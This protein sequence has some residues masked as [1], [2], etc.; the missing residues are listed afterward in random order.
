[1]SDSASRSH[2]KEPVAGGDPQQGSSSSRRPAVVEGVPHVAEDQ[3]TVI[4]RR[5]PLAPVSRPEAEAPARPSDLPSGARL[6]HFELLEYVGGGG[7]GRVFRALDTRLG[8][9]VALKV[10]SRDQ[11]GQTE[12][13]M[14]FRN[15]ARSAA[16]LSHESIAQVYFV[17]EDDGL[18]F[19]AFEFVEGGNLRDLVTEKGALPLAEALSYTLQVAEALAHAAEYHIVH[20]DIKPS[21]VLITSEGRVKLIDLGLAR[22]KKIGGS[23]NDLTASGVTL[24]TFDYI[25]PEQARD[26]RNAD[27]RSDIYSL[28]CTLFFMF[29][30]RPPFPAGTVLQKLLQHQG[31]EPPDVR[32]FRPDLPEEVSRLVRKMMAKE[33][34]RRYQDPPTLIKALLLLA[35]RVGLGVVGVKHAAWAPTETRRVSFLHRHI[36]WMAPITGLALSVVLLHVLWTSSAREDDQPLRDWVGGPARIVAELPAV[37]GRLNPNGAAP[38]RETPV[39]QSPD[40]P[41]DNTA[42]TEPA[43]PGAEPREIATPPAESTPALPAPPA[44]GGVQS[45]PAAPLEPPADVAKPNPLEGLLSSGAGQDALLPEVLEGGVSLPGESPAGLSVDVGETAEGAQLSVATA[46]GAVAKPGPSAEPTA[47]RRP[48]LVVEPQADGEG[49]FATL[50]A[51][52]RAARPGDVIELR[53]NGR[54]EEEPLTLANVEFT[55]RAGEG[56]Q[57]VIGFRP[58]EIDPVGFPRSMFNLIGSRLT[59]INVAIELDMPRDAPSDR[60]SLFEIGQ[61][62]KVTLQN[63]RLTIRN[64]ADQRAAYHQEVSFFRLKAAP[65]TIAGLQNTTSE[66][67]RSVA[68]EL[69]GCVVRGEAVFLHTEDLQPVDLVWRN[70]FLITTEQL[71]VADGG[72]RAPRPDETLGIS[73]DHVTAVADRGLLRLEHSEFAPHQLPAHLDCTKCVFLL[74]PEASL[75]EQVGVTDMEQAAERI[76]WQGDDNVY[77]GFTRFWTTGHLDPGIAS[78][79]KT[80]DDWQADWT[81]TGEQ[82]PRLK[83]TEREKLPGPDRPAHT[84]TPADYAPIAEPAEAAP[85]DTPEPPA[86]KVGETQPAGFQPGPLQS[87]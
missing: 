42:R 65:G 13:L 16:R 17:G 4:S 12:A 18:P 55:I 32:E 60:W 10:L 21:N 83:T 48:L 34:H 61:G 58:S 23:A 62:E 38:D 74:G 45:P 37:E 30:G 15:E 33:P 31:I 41:T 22:M 47:E 63:C 78:V 29:T 1:M 66:P 40:Q 11:A 6:E 27:I 52:C 84:L 20:R 68:V 54:L 46:T 70:G 28:G 59:L 79:S 26:P 35:E 25:S 72:E 76:R 53:Y 85:A 57:P 77:R 56:F 87:G 49:R 2:L 7:M 75:V 81:S 67:A 14:R 39:S 24:G 44:S 5:P 80:F 51:A 82:S 71:V 43:A 64:A 9:T 86:E 36:P 73:L 69:A 3:P 50:G 8:R 19:I